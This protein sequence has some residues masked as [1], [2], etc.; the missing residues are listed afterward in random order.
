MNNSTRF[1]PRLFLRHCNKDGGIPYAPTGP[2]FSEPTLMMILALAAAG[3]TIHLAQPLV[4]WILKNR[5]RNGSIGL[6]SEFPNEGIWNTPLLA[7]AMHRLGLKAERDA[8]IDFIIKAHSIAIKRS[9]DNIMNTQLSGWS[10]VENTFGW[11][12]PTSWA[13]L[14]LSIA[15]KESHPRA[16]EGRKLLEDR[17]I[18]GGGWNFG[19]K[20]V[21]NHPLLPFGD[22][23]ALA[24][25]ALGDNS[26]AQMNLDLLEKS[27]PETDSLYTNSLAA[28]CLARFGRSADEIR[29]RILTLLESDDISSLNLAHSALGTIALSR[30]RVLTL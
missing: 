7:I 20:I 8:A 22:T 30:R 28:I 16:V 11:V 17:C 4:D 26:I 2:S 9:S 1:S 24:L 14:A 23:T 12:E 18:P 5:N 3:E 25:L 15:G 10:W 19:N 27:I 21:F 13:L 29:N 6:N